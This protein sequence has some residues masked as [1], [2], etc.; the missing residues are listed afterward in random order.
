MNVAKS[1]RGSR[2][3]ARSGSGQ[4]RRPL[5]ARRRNRLARGLT[6]VFSW[7]RTREPPGN[8]QLGI[9]SPGTSLNWSISMPA[10]PVETP[11]WAG[12]SH[13]AAGEAPISRGSG[14]S[15]PSRWTFGWEGS[16]GQRHFGKRRPSDAEACPNGSRVNQGHTGST[17]SAVTNSAQTAQLLAPNGPEKLTDLRYHV[18]ARR[19]PAAR[20]GGISNLRESSRALPALRQPGDRHS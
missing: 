15:V 16:V 3:S 11:S 17:A 7:G 9:P 10:D 19:Q 1:V 4:R 12:L 2:A 14:L 18:E 8:I 20:S 13:V 5:V 6:G